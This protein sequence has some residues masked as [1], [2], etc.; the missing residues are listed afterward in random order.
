MRTVVTDEKVLKNAYLRSAIMETAGMLIAGDLFP[1]EQIDSF[2][3]GDVEKLFSNE[4]V[5]LFRNADFSV[6]NR[7]IDRRRH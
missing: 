1:R 3:H 6:C 5:E 2:A 4:I 7:C